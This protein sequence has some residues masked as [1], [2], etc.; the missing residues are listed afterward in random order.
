MRQGEHRAPRL[1]ER[2]RVLVPRCRICNGPHLRHP[3]GWCLC[4]HDYDSNHSERRPDWEW[5]NGI[6]RCSD[7][8]ECRKKVSE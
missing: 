2:R 8:R 5:N 7:C 3:K 1:R 4:R 6:A